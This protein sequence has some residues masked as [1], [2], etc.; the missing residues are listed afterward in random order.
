MNQTVIPVTVKARKCGRC[1]GRI[2]EG[3]E[4]WCFMCGDRPDGFVFMAFDGGDHMTINPKRTHTQGA[5][6]QRGHEMKGDNIQRNGKLF[7][8]RAC[9]NLRARGMLP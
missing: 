3:E 2:V 5:M 6:C 7:R 1:S 9:A 8:C 4:P